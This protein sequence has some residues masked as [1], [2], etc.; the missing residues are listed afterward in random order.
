MSPGFIGGRNLE[1]TLGKLNCFLAG[2][3]ILPNNCF[4]IYCPAEYFAVGLE[5]TNA[6]VLLGDI[7][8]VPVLLVK[9]SLIPVRLM[10]AIQKNC[11]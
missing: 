1:R 8:L 7:Y 11:E 2:D 10:N 5:P 6:R 4:L 3:N 9:C